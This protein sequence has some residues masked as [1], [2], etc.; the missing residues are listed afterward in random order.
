[1]HDFIMPI[2]PQSPA[3]KEPILIKLQLNGETV[4]KATMVTG[5]TH[6]GIE[7]ILEGK[8]PD[9]ALY[10]AC[11]V[12]GICSM[13]H[14][15]GYVRTVENIL[16]YEAPERVK[17]LRTIMFEL[18]RMQSHLLWAG[19]MMHEIGLETLF[20]YYWRER[21]KILDAFEKTTGGRV[22][23]NLNKIRTLRY[24]LEDPEYVKEKVSSAAK[25]SNE[26]YKDMINEEAVKSR[27]QNIG[28]I[29]A[30][31][32][33]KW[34]LNG[35]IAR[36]SGINIDT[37]KDDPYDWYPKTGFKIIT[38]KTGDSMDRLKVRLEEIQESARVITKTINNL[39]EEEIP[40]FSLNQVNGEGYARVEAPRGELFY[41]LRFKNSKV[42]R[43]KIR[44]PSFSYMKILEELLPGVKIGDVPVIIASLDP[45]FSCL[46]RVLVEKKGSISEMDEDQFRRQ[47]T[48]TR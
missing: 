38:G 14:E 18:E 17:A 32:A 34:A 10:A 22:H 36:A 15:R 4:N 6:R 37:R 21:E 46:E 7:Y 40:K 23:H 26:Y 48:C 8:N 31:M 25:A 13:S 11:R 29:P 33:V 30:D 16:G 5:Y 19:F 20:N 24:D 27:L 35:P 1:M 2:G 43:A 9:Q 41:Y 44:T 39:P 3:I 47:Y 45:C 28:V 12:C 42:E